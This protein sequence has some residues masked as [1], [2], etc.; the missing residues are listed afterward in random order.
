MSRFKNTAAVSTGGALNFIKPAELSRAEFEGVV[1]E[2]EFV[3]ALPNKFNADKNDFKIKVDTALKVTGK[4]KDG[5]PYSIELAPGDTVIVNGAGNLGW[6]MSNVSPGE[7]CQI[8]YQGKK[9]IEKG[10][11]AGMEAHNFVVNYGA[12]E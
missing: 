2:G 4:T 11:K 7:I 1:A 12:D 3:E 6:Q 10:P 8:V 5:E 9:E